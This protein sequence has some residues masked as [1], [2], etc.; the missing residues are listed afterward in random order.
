MWVLTVGT[1]EAQSSVSRGSVE[2]CALAA[3]FPALGYKDWLCC[4]WGCVGTGYDSAAASGE[5]VASLWWEEE[6]GGPWGSG[7][8]HCRTPV[9]QDLSVSLE[10][11]QEPC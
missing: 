5:V 11:L 2:V 8:L 4:W 10:G 7:K 6:C 3:R 1:S 9:G